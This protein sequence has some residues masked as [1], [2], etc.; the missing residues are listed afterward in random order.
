MDK[1]GWRC[2]ACANTHIHEPSSTIVCEYCDV[3][4]PFGGDKHY[5]RP[6]LDSL[7]AEMRRNRLVNQQPAGQEP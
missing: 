5:T 1:F 6:T 2:R 3:K 7:F 4:D